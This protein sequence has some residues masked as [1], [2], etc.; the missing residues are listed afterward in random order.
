MSLETYLE[1]Q[2]YVSDHTLP[3]HLNQQ[4]FIFEGPDGVGKTEISRGLSDLLGIPYF[5]MAT[6]HDNWRKNKFQTALEFDQTYIAEFLSQ[7]GTSAIIDRAFPSEYVY[8]AVY[9]RGT[10]HEVLR[11]VDKKFAEFGATIILLLRRDYENSRED[12]LVDKS[13]LRALHNEYVAFAGW[14]QCNVIQ[15]YVDDLLN[16]L[17]LQ[18]PI[19]QACIK[20]QEPKK[21]NMIVVP[22]RTAEA[23]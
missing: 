22:Y 5:R 13:K 9:K 7:T 18:L 17:K 4:V 2:E 12:D 20:L 19:L 10:N 21:K 8:S 14:T 11:A 3:K 23:R 16:D 1:S 6:Q 15:L